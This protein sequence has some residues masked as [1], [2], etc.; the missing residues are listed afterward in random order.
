M[1]TNKVEIIKASVSKK[2]ET[3]KPKVIKAAKIIGIGVAGIAI[4]YGAS[5]IDADQIIHGNVTE[6]DGSILTDAEGEFTT[7][8]ENIT[9]EVETI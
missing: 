4:G 7:E 6:D 5:K 2:I 9:T 8:E 1:D 3:I